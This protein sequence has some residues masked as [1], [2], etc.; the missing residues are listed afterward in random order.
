[1]SPD[2]GSDEPTA[3][4]VSRREAKKALHRRRILETAQ[5]VFFRDGFVEANL[6]EIARGAGVAKGTLYRYFDSKA[7]LYVAVLAHGGDIFAERMRAARGEGL[8]AADQIRRI[9]RFYFEHWTANEDYFAIFWA[10]ENQ[11]LIGEL[12][13]DAVKQVTSLWSECLRVLADAIGQGVREGSF[14][15]CDPWEVANIFWTVANGLIRT[16]HV[17]ARRRLRRSRLDRIFDDAVELLLRGLTVPS[18]K[19]YR[20]A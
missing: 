7:D 8:D 15:P 19:I 3:G 1:M 13:P 12:T 18:E 11:Q 9:A 20:G 2:A 10:V 5:E 6:D 16:E 4:S 17:T 14:A